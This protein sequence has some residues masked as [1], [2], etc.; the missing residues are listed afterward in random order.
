MLQFTVD[1]KDENSRCSFVDKGDRLTQLFPAVPNQ[2][3]D[4]QRQRQRPRWQTP[5]RN[6]QRQP[7]RVRM[8]PLPPDPAANSQRQQSRNRARP[9]DPDSRPQ[10]LASISLH[11]H[12]RHAAC[13]TYTITPVT[14]TYSQI[15]KVHRA[16]L[17][18]AG[19][20][21]VSDR[22]NVIKING[23]ATVDSTICDASSFQ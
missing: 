23:S 17:L 1:S 11:G 10:Q 6:H 3:R 7:P 12:Y 19:K 13:I 15:G 22:K 4:R 2:L 21:P 14:E 8:R 18:C 20:R 5:H 9:E 16:S